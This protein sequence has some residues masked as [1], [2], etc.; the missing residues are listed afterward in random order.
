MKRV[1]VVGSTNLDTIY[2]VDRPLTLHYKGRASSRVETVGGS[3]ANTAVWLADAGCA[4]SLFSSVGTDEAGSFCLRSLAKSPHLDLSN[5]IRHPGTT[6]TAV[7][8]T[9][10]LD[11]VIVTYADRS[12]DQPLSAQARADDFHHIHIA[13]R[14]S[15]RTAVDLLSAK[16]VRT[17][18]SL[19]LNGRTSSAFAPYADVIFSNADDL[20]LTGELTRSDA[21]GLLA[22]IG[23][24]PTT[25]LVLTRGVRGSVCFS[26]E[27]QPV[28]VEAQMVDVIDR[29]GAGD[30]F[31]AGF[32]TARLEDRPIAQCLVSG[33]DFATRCLRLVGGGL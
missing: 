29:T 20:G 32:L 6:S 8:I 19:E 22:Q 15:N 9:S 3:A 5:V 1:A 25:L 7:C 33:Q 23:A 10:P 21:A 14:D 16:S 2:Y 17:S 28:A 18:V 13:A 24:R 31:D 27:N 11:K 12:P 26:S 30:A 4:V